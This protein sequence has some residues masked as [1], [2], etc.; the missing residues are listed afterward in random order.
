MGV[1]HVLYNI[2]LSDKY[3]HLLKEMCWND[4]YLIIGKE[5]Q[6]VGNWHNNATHISIVEMHV[7]MVD[8]NTVSPCPCHMMLHIYEGRV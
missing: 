2:Q 5:D 1:F 4:A 7:R 8:M 3:E 6:Y